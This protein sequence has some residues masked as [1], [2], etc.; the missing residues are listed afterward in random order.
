MQ[1]FAEI[2]VF[3]VKARLH[4]TTLS[5]FTRSKK[6]LFFNFWKQ[7][8]YFTHLT[9]IGTRTLRGC[10]DEMDEN[11]SLSCG[12]ETNCEICHAFSGNV[13][14]NSNVSESKISTQRSNL[15]CRLWLQV[16]PQNRLTCHQCSDTLNSNS[17]CTAVDVN[18]KACRTYNDFDRCY[19]RKTSNLSSIK[20]QVEILSS[21]W[22][23][24][25]LNSL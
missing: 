19:I 24:N 2:F 25:S 3:W 14:C 22:T 5:T 10:V 23:Q 20:K 12:N 8:Q 11:Q 9:P 15:K 1:G 21:N 18:P 7:I 4:N 6:S 13:G 16:Y 17:N